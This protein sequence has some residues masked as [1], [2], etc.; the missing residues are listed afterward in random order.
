MCI[1]N[2]NKKGI[3]FEYDCIFDNW[4]LTWQAQDWPSLSMFLQKISKKKNENR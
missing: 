1:G 2:I 3:V 4:A